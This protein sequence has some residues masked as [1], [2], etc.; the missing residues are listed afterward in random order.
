M[1]RLHRLL[2]EKDSTISYEL[3][4]DAVTTLRA[5]NLIKRDNDGKLFA[6]TD[7]E[8]TLGYL[9]ILVKGSSNA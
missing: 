8:R 6:L 1:E 4:H 9:G 5:D 7:E 2:A 3:F